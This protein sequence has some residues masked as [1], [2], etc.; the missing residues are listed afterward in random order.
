MINPKITLGYSSCPNDTFIFYALA[1]QLIDTRGFD[2]DITI[3][4]VE[5]L[6]FRAMNAELMVSKLSFAA[7]FH[8]KDKYR[9]LNV[10]A[11]LGNGCGPLIVAKKDFD[12][13]RLPN[14]R[15]AIPGRLTTAA[16]LLSLFLNSRADTFPMRFD[17]IMPAVSSGEYDAG[18]IIHEGRFTYQKYGLVLV[19]DLGKWWENTTGLPI[20][21]GGIAV[22]G[23]VPGKTADYIEKTIRESLV[24]ARTHPGE[25]D[26]YIKMHA[27]EL[28]DD[29]IARHIDLYVNDYSLDLGETG[30]RAV[31]LLFEMA[32]EINR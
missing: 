3:A 13:D 5:E 8:L 31:S 29:V 32:E 30:A 22:R 1:N 26:D 7:I 4:D 23:D 9:L 16:L 20:P 24:Y 15:I 18:V 11:A 28:S 17:M 14:A 19:C 25:A 2:Y 6:N 12:K 27:R 21:L 10:G